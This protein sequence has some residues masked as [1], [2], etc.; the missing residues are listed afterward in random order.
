MIESP[1]AMILVFVAGEGEVEADGEVAGEVDGV[2]GMEGDDGVTPPLHAM[3]FTEKSAGT[4]FD[5]VQ[6]PLNPIEAVPPVPS[7]P[8]QA[9]LRTVTAAPDWLTDPFHS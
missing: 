7:D 9:A 2:P 4:G 1:S 3:P 5:P 6:D 8:F